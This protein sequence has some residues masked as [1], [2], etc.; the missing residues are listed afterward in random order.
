MATEAESRIDELLDGVDTDSV[1]SM[2]RFIT[3]VKLMRN[4]LR[5][6]EKKRDELAAVNKATVEQAVTDKRNVIGY[7]IKSNDDGSVLLGGRT[8]GKFN[9][10]DAARFKD[11]LCAYRQ[12]DLIIGRGKTFKE[13]YLPQVNE[14]LADGKIG[15]KV[16]REEA[17]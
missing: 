6:E 3:C 12:M 13:M 14:L 1:S 8:F 11:A 15:R 17:L 9:P 5:R 7:I 4:E 16:E 10:M 2:R